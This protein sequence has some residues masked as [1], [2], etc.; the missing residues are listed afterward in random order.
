MIED[1][2]DGTESVGLGDRFVSIL[3]PP[4]VE[5]LIAPPISDVFLEVRPRLFDLRLEPATDC[6]A[7]V[8]VVTDWRDEEG[9]DC[10]VVI[11]LPIREC[12]LFEL[13]KPF[14]L[15]VT[16]DLVEIEFEGCLVVI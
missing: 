3:E 13:V 8:S 12:V 2:A 9:D 6:L 4:E 11:C 14:R 15:L 7:V 5:G 16:P 1:L 10:L